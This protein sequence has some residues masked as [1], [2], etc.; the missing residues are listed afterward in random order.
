MVEFIQYVSVFK[1]IDN[2]IK[3]CIAQNASQETVTPGSEISFRQ[4]LHKIK[5]SRIYTNLR[6]KKTERPTSE[7]K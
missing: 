1:C 2:D 6:D 4:C 5:P 7:K 3:Q